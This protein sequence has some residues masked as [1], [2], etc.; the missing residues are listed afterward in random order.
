MQANTFV[1]F[2]CF[3][4]VIIISYSINLVLGRISFRKGFNLFKVTANY[5][6]VAAIH[7]YIFFFIQQ[8]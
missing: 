1:L 3:W 5:S 8:K 4:T 2:F 7:L 6:K